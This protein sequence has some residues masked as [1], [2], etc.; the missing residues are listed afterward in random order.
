MRARRNPAVS[1]VSLTNAPHGCCTVES[2]FRR[3]TQRRRP[4][5]EPVIDLVDDGLSDSEIATRLA[6]WLL[7]LEAVPVVVLPV[8]AIDELRNAYADDDV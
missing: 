6:E 3:G 2:I 7:E 8:S 4:P 1:A 5:V